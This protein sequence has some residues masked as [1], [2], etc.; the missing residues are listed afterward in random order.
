MD[1]EAFFDNFSEFDRELDELKQSLMR[2]VKKEI[3]DK[4]DRLEKELAELNEFRTQ[5]DAIMKERNEE[6]HRCAA[7]VEEANRNARRARLRELMADVQI[8]VWRVKG[9]DSVFVVPKCGK[10]DEKRNIHFVSPGGKEMTEACE[11]RKIKTLYVPAK[12]VLVEFCIDRGYNKTDIYTWY[13]ECSDD[14]DRMT[15]GIPAKG[16]WS[17]EQGF[18]QETNAWSLVF[19]T[20][21]DCRAYCAFLNADIPADATPTSGAKQC[22]EEPTPCPF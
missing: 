3:T 16:F 14:P 20:E 5:R 7:I 13:R 8:E 4:I 9:G 15:N 18:S 22:S 1:G 21:E 17:T 11:C 6:S 19:R 12:E 10:C 2:G